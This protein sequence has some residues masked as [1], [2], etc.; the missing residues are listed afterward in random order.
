MASGAVLAGLSSL[1]LRAMSA[2]S[3]TDKIKL[4][5]LHTNDQH[6]HI[7]PFPAN[8]PKFPGMG[9]FARR[10][11]IINDIR[12]AENNIL[13]FDAGDIFQGTPYFNFFG[14]EPEFKLMSEMGYDAATLGNH[15]FDNGLDGLAKVLPNAKFPFVSSN[16][17]FSE[18]PVSGKIQKYVILH[19]EGI[20]IGVFGLGVKLEGLVP[21]NAYGKTRYS[22]PI[23]KAA[24]MSLFLKKEK[25]CDVIICLSHMG[26]DSDNGGPCDITLAKQSKNIDIIIGGHSHRTLEPAYCWKNS[27]GEDIV[28]AQVGWGGVKLGRIDL[29]FDKKS[30]KK[31][32]ISSVVK[33]IKN[34]L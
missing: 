12:K 13:L 33:I 21:K 3:T 30:K 1:P 15:D 29:L 34:Q 18:T 4:V 16:Y 7:E 19:R 27:D 6:S 5:I 24:E 25:K 32:T 10:A 9:G 28:I 22:D 20:R 17:D 8:D 23:V 14:G 2:S 26:V 11:S 31:E